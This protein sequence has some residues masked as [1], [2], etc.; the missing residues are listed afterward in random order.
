MAADKSVDTT[1]VQCILLR[2]RPRL[3]AHQVRPVCAG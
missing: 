3:T 1:Y 2:G